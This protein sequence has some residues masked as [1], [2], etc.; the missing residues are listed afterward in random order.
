MKL[1][2]GLGGPSL[3]TNTEVKALVAIRTIDGQSIRAVTLRDA[4]SN[5]LLFAADTA[6]G[7]P[8]L[9]DAEL[10]RQGVGVLGMKS[11]GNGIIL[12][13]GAVTAKAILRC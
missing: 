4:A 5:E 11:L 6:I 2:G 1:P 10:V 12:R 3:S 13:S 9:R 7:A 8:V